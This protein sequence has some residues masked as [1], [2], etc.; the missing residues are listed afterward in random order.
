MDQ[1]F[2]HHKA[3]VQTYLWSWRWRRDPATG[4]WCRC[5][6]G[7]DARSLAGE[8]R[9]GT[10][11]FPQSS[12]CALVTNPEVDLVAD[13]LDVLLPEVFAGELDVIHDALELACD[14]KEGNAGGAGG[15]RP[16]R[17][18]SDRPHGLRH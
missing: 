1:T 4:A 13:V 11:R 9:R 2:A 14:I 6:F 18:G 17:R 15:G 8:F 12:V 7:T 10:P 5:S 3:A 16:W